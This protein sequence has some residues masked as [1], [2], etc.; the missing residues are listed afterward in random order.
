MST[1]VVKVIAQQIGLD[2]YR[3]Q[4]IYSASGQMKLLGTITLKCQFSKDLT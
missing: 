2:E 3:G 1:Y 4:P